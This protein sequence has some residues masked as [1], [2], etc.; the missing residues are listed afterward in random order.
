M[1]G[2][3]T[4]TEFLTELQR[5]LNG[6]MGSSEAAPHVA[7]Y[8]EYIEIQVRKGREEEA[9]VAELGS[10]RLIGKNIGDANDRI[11]QNVDYREKA[12]EYGEKLLEYGVWT[13]KKCAALGLAAVD[14]VK[15]WFD[16]L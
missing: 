4:K 9:V 6:R 2:F 3:M 12:R 16:R 1:E 14:K 5:T 8:Q 10:P 13:G 11:S 7:Y 15:T